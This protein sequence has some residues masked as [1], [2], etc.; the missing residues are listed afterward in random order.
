MSVSDN[1][2][3]VWAFHHV[4]FGL[5]ASIK[6]LRVHGVD[7]KMKAFG[8]DDTYRTFR[9]DKMK[10]MIEDCERHAPP[11]PSGKCAANPTRIVDVGDTRFDPI[12]IN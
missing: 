3:S 7:V 4:Y 10:E 2:G 12:C 6:R 8:L 11:R 1:E 5:F 9:F